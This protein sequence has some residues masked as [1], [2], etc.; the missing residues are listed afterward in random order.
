MPTGRRSAERFAER[1]TFQNEL[2]ALGI[3]DS[4]FSTPTAS[5]NLPTFLL[6]M[7]SPLSVRSDDEPVRIPALSSNGSPQLSSLN[8]NPGNLK[9]ARQTGAVPG[10]GG[11]AR[12]ET[13]EDGYRALIDQIQLDAHR[14]Y[15]LQEYITK[16]APPSENDTAL[17]VAQACQ[18]L[19]VD[20]NT[21]LVQV[22]VN[23][24][25]AFQ[26]RKESGTI[27][28]GKFGV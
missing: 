10:V 1:M 24:L 26:A 21:P 17:Y 16:Y 19:G 14:G 2:A 13:A 25:A 11:F 12:F 6:N 22:D 5:T 3:G 28:S 8:N 23:K 15:T 7:Q 20:S 9:F 4:S 18:S 27:I